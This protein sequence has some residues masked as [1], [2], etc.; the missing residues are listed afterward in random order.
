[1]T[2]DLDAILAGLRALDERHRYHKIDY[3]EPYPKQED[4]FAFGVQKR[5]RLLMAGNQ[6]GKTYAGAAE[7]AFH[8]TGDYP[9]WWTGR[10]INHSVAGWAAGETSILVRDGPQ[11][12]LCGQPG[13]EE[14]FGT[15]LIPRDRF[16]GKP[17][18]ARGVTDAYDTIQV[19][20]ATGGI[21][22]LTFKSYEQ[23]RPKFQSAT[24]DF[25]WLDEEPPIDI[26]SE[27]LA[28]FTATGGFLFMTFTPLKGMSDVVSRFLHE[29]SED[30]S[31]TNM[32]IEDAKHIP[33]DERAKIIAGYPEHEREARAR[34]VPMLGEGRVFKI[35]EET[36][37]EPIIDMLPTVWV[38]GWGIDFGIGHN[39][40]AVLMAWDRDSDVIHILNAIRM[41][42][43]D[44]MKHAIRMKMIG[45]NVPVF[46][47]QDGNQRD[48]GSGRQLSL[49]YKDQGLLMHPLMAT[50]PEG[51]N[52][53]EPGVAEM[54]NRM[55]TG[56]LKV[57]EHLAEWFEEYRMYHRKDGLVVKERDDLLSA[58]RYGIMMKR[59]W[60]ATALGGTLKSRRPQT[61]A[62]D[63]DFPLFG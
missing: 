36:I 1:M 59:Y 60:K 5:E 61:V 2:V 62:K 48:K 21:S 3:F 50:W 30:R 46:W 19:R 15:G 11:K 7:V 43:G 10:R 49:Q 32:V 52:A 34:G 57:V 17:S 51:G 41:K 47:P 53:F 8:L 39:F 29:P 20:H 24:L 40:A 9:W 26:Y 13:V 16:V 44:A 45:I 42:D 37:R 6:L 54:E 33:A 4:F 28:R 63:V 18:L 22:T 38:K 25:I 27:C 23:G 58:T 14:A 55:S 31:V 56:R 35:A 12:L